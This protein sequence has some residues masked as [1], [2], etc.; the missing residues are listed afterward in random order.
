M[1]KDTGFNMTKSVKTTPLRAQILQQ[2]L[3]LLL[4]SCRSHAA[5][6]LSDS[7]LCEDECF[8][9][10]SRR[11][12]AWGAK[13]TKHQYSRLLYLL[14]RL[15]VSNFIVRHHDVST[16]VVKVSVVGAD[17]RVWLGVGGRHSGESEKKEGRIGKRTEVG[18][19]VS[20]WYLG[21]K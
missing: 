8:H 11:R 12:G 2:V 10:H 13:S 5:P 18:G 4:T 3:H 21:Q 9:G 14:C 15:K 19:W 17:G 1:D 6:R 16:E 20:K 7:R